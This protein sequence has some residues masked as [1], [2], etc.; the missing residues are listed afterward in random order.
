MAEVEFYARR[1]R[2]R[3][4]RRAAKARKRAFILA[5]LDGLSTIPSDDDRWLD[6]FS[7]TPVESSKEDEDDFDW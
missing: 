6:L 1:K 7:L 5:Q 2:D 3:A 4:R